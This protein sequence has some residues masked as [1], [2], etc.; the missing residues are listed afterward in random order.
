MKNK[1]A[2][3]LLLILG[4][5]QMVGNLLNQPLIS[6]IAAAFNA[7]P[8]P[9]VFSAAKGLETYSTDF[10]LEWNDTDGKSHSLQLTPTVNGKIRGPYNRRNV[11]GAAIAYGPVLAT[12]EKTRPMFE[13][14]LNYSLGGDA[15]LLREL[16]IDPSTIT[17]P[18][19][20][21]LVVEP[22]TKL[23]TEMPLLFEVNN[24]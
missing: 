2:F 14:V 24:E 8:H 3:P 15:P 5:L 16:G 13:A 7:S 19:V 11:F 17:Y 20:L 10:F 21:R 22:G 6:G 1:I 12:N 23:E 18:V 9:K 4:L